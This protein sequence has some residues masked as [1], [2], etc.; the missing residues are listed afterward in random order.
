[1]AGHRNFN[2]LRGELARRLDAHPRGQAIRERSAADLRRGLAAHE[3]AERFGW[4]AG[5]VTVHHAVQPKP[6]DA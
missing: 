6:P 3:R 4:R 5:D 1:M 2:A